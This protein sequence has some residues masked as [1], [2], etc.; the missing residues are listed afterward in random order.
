[1]IL[2]G[3][4]NVYPAEIEEALHEHSK[5]ADAAVIGAPHEKWEEVPL[6]AILLREGESADQK[7][8]LA[9]CKAKLAKYKIPHTV[10][11]VEPL[12]RSLQGKLLKYKLRESDR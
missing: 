12:S 5:I 10:D 3:A 1:M 2:S 8:I 9:L 11:F 7:E 6:A 4:I